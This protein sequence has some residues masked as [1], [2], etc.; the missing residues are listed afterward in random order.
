M[1]A[2]RARSCPRTALQITLTLCVLGATIGLAAAQQASKAQASA[3][4][5]ACGTD[6]MRYC[7][8]VRPGRAAALGCLQR[9][10]ASLSPRCRMVVSAIGAAGARP[11]T[12]PVPAPPQAASRRQ[13]ASPQQQAL[14]SACRRDFMA[15]C[16]RVRPNGSAA[17]SCL[18]RNAGSLSPPCRTAVSAA[19]GGIAP[20]AARPVATNQP[21]AGAQPAALVQSQPPPGAN[22]ASVEAVS[23]RVVAFAHGKPGLLENSD[24]IG[25]RTRLDLQPDSELRFCHFKANRVLALRGPARALVSADG[26][27][28]EN[29][30]AVG[31]DA[32]S[33]TRPASR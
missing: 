6:Y 1:Q 9:N 29:G 19:G 13:P 16:S 30:R 4:R 3:L 24:L 27:T 11:A 25:D 8:R 12:Q 33:C 31:A 15:Y 21:A 20:P 14:H 18:Q 7:A 5:A 22:V 10:A 32:G 17:L 23:G 2:S 28:D 26:V